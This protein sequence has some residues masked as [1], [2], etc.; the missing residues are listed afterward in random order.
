MSQSWPSI[1]QTAQGRRYTVLT[2]ERSTPPR[3]PG[4]RLLDFGALFRLEACCGVE[5][6]DCLLFVSLRDDLRTPERLCKSRQ[7]ARFDIACLT[8]MVDER[9]AI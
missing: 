1:S 4:L 8:P 7:W 2:D 3:A 5:P 6:L 9:V